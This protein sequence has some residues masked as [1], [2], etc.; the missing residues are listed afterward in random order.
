MD[1]A[2]VRASEKVWSKIDLSFVLLSSSN[3]ADPSLTNAVV[4]GVWLGYLALLL[5]LCSRGRVRTI[6]P[7]R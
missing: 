1:D 5:R 6:T 7:G 3:S 4:M 2:L